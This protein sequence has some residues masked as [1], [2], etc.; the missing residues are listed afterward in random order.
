MNQ[1]ASELNPQTVF[2]PNCKS[3]CD[4]RRMGQW[5]FKR[6]SNGRRYWCNRCRQRRNRDGLAKVQARKLKYPNLGPGGFSK[7]IAYW[8]KRV[9]REIA[10]L[11][12]HASA[13]RALQIQACPKWVRSADI[14]SIYH[15]CR[16]A[17][18]STSIPHHVD[19]IV[20]LKSKYVCGLHVPW[21]LR[22]ITAEENLQKSNKFKPGPQ[23]A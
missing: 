8:Q 20:P 12:A 14:I 18:E 13:R 2:C 7:K 6:N 3:Q 9:D 1:Q 10:R 22:V 21:N 4:E 15:Q 23:S 11:N 19:H 16:Q 5:R 17:T